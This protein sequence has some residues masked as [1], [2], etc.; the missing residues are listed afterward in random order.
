MP[1]LAP[2]RLIFRLEKTAAM[3]NQSI[4]KFIEGFFPPTELGL[5]RSHTDPRGTKPYG[6]VR[7][8]A[9]L[10]GFFLVLEAK[11]LSDYLS[12]RSPY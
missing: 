5:G 9:N 11:Q 7:V 2:F 10:G 12:M 8:D 1:D 4:N 6:W 3:P